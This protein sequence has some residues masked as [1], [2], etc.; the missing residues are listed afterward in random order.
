MLLRA[1]LAC[2]LS[3][4]AAWAQAPQPT[5]PV[6]EVVSIRQNIAGGR[7]ASFGL[8]PDG[9]R[10]VNMPVARLILTAYTPTDGS[11]IYW[12]PKGFPVWVS[13]DKW[14]M[15][16][17]VSDAER[18]AWQ[19][20]KQQ[21]KLLQAM[22]QQM[23]ADRCKLVVHRVS[24]DAQ[25]YYLEVG[26]DGPKLQEAADGEAQPQNGT[27]PLPGGGMVVSQGPEMR[28]YRAP[29][30]LLASWLTNRNLGGRPVLDR[31]DLTGRYDFAVPWGRW[32]GGVGA[33][34]D[35]SDPG[36]TL[37]SSVKPLG[38]KLV[39]A[40]GQVENLVLDHVERPSE[41]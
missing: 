15:E 31:T 2:L 25:V 11:A 4:G 3:C 38:L 18:A 24:E 40:K 20:A 19:D 34:D 27:V 29:M 36:P 22:L 23:L 1:G 6:F 14:D 16:A 12:E 41:N 9:F 17:R 10:M 32:T 37:E 5:A 26:K 7:N 39:P 35:A 28:F 21:P 8:T 13:G 33:T 30:T